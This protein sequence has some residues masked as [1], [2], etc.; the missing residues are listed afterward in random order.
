MA[1][2]E[3]QLALIGSGF[4]VFG[5][6]HATPASV[7]EF[8]DK[9]RAL[10]L[11]PTDIVVI[12]FKNRIQPALQRDGHWDLTVLTTGGTPVNLYTHRETGRRVVNPR[13][14]YG[15]EMNQ[16]LGEFYGRGARTFYLLGTAG[17]LDPNIHVGDLALPVS[18]NGPGN[19]KITIQNEVLDVLGPAGKAGYHVVNHG[20][21]QTILDETVAETKDLRQKGIQTVDIEGR[22]L[23]EFLNSHKDVRGGLALIISDEPLG[24]TNYL[25]NNVTLSGV[26]RALDRIVAPLFA[27]EGK[28]AERS[29]SGC[30][31]DLKALTGSE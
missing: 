23:I 14:V 18:F 21:I 13:N 15:D 3:Q 26:D 25:A 8:N 30:A 6:K 27:F 22:Y 20:W 31:H 7:F 29:G 1:R 17:A 12:G 16:V 19:E 24:S 4:E 10:S 2:I 9:G 5:V 28:R 11:E